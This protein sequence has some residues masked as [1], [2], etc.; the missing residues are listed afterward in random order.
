M[1]VKPGK[2]ETQDEFISRCVSEEVSSG[3]EQTQAVAVCYS[4]WKDRRR[5]EFNGD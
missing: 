5:K 1:P 3:M 4:K 2:N